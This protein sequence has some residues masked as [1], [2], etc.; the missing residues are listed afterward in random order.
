MEKDGDTHQA[1]PNGRLNETPESLLD[2]LGRYGPGTTPISH[3]GTWRT[4]TH[5]K[6]LDDK[7]FRHGIGDADLINRVAVP[8]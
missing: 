3:P 2:Q 6:I 1:V 7:V 8:N 5:P 4:V